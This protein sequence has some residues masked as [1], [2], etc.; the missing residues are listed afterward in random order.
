MTPEIARMLLPVVN[1][2]QAM[3]ALLAY[4][5]YR[6]GLAREDNDRAQGFDQ[7]CRNQ[8]TVREL[9]R[10]ATLRDEVIQKAKQ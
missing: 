9:Q 10:F 8:G 7:V 3:E 1:N 2:R 4:A 5:N 6:M